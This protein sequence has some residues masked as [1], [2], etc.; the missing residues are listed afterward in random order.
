[1]W[2]IVPSLMSSL[3]IVKSIL[4]SADCYFFST[5]MDATA[6]RPVT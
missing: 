1:M 4:P 5:I 6:I 3:S 2:R